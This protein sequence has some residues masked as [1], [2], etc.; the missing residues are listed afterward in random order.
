MSDSSI[1]VS[2]NVVLDL[3]IHRN[4]QEQSRTL[5]KREGILINLLPE[6]PTI[7]AKKQRNEIDTCVFYA[8]L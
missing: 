3:G 6:A 4:L 5:Q 7:S 1:I 8:Y 2:Y